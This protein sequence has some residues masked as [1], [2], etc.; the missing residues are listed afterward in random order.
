VV[1]GYGVPEEDTFA[2]IMEKRLNREN[3][4][5]RKFYEVINGGIPAYNSELELKF[6][7]EEGFDYHPHMVILCYI[8]NDAEIIVF[9]GNNNVLHNAGAAIREFARLHLRS[10][11]FLKTCFKRLYTGMGQ[12]RTVT[13]LYEENGEGWIRAMEAVKKMNRLCTDKGIDFLVVIFPRLEDL[14]KKSVYDAL[15]EKIAEKLQDNGIQVLNLFPTF[16][17][18]EEEKLW[19]SRRDRHPNPVAHRNA[20]LAIYPHVTRRH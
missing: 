10:L 5:H 9:S 18:H 16:Q 11:F 1:F 14:S 20:A 8:L 17:G 19:V 13:D 2:S 15:Y 4:G 3:P 6:L 7:E 12:G